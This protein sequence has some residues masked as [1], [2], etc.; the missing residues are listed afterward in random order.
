MVK[1]IGGRGVSDMGIGTWGLGG[2]SRPD[3]SRDGES[4]DAIRHAFSRGINLI[5]TAE[6]YGGGHTEEVVGSAMEGMERGNFFVTTKLWHNNLTREKVRRSTE[7]SLKRLKMEYVDLL[8][9]HWPNPDVPVK[10]TIRSME[11]MYREGK[12][13]MIG[14]SNFNVE[15]LKEAMDACRDAEISANQIEYNYLKRECE[16]EVIK[17]C[18][19]NKIAVIAY[20]PINRGNL[21][22]SVVLK[23]MAQKYDCKPVQIALRYV[24]ERSIPIPKSSSREHLDE[25]LESMNI[26]LSREDYRKLASS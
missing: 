4:I 11:E 6:M 22:N 17:F 3:Y 9:I 8:L 25:L 7:N 18:E 14:V 1:F 15:Q 13:R 23:E 2:K 10:E 12:T 24:L 5:D 26:K 16:N 21:G 19:D 20:S